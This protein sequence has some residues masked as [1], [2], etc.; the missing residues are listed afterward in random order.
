MYLPHVLDCLHATQEFG[1]FGQLVSFRFC[2]VTVVVSGYASYSASWDPESTSVKRLLISFS[3]KRETFLWHGN[4]TWTKAHSKHLGRQQE[5]VKARTWLLLDSIWSGQQ[6]CVGQ[7]VRQCSSNISEQ[8]RLR[9]T[10]RS[11]EAFQQKRTSADHS[12]TAKTN[13][14]VQC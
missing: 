3:F 5:V 4:S 7:V 11:C 13:L 12:Q 8:Y 14:S 9:R 6:D 2:H 1:G 10:T